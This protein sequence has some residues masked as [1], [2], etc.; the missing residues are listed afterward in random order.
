MNPTFTWYPMDAGNSDLGETLPSNGN[1]KGLVYLIRETTQNA[2]DA[3]VDGE[4]PVRVDFELIRF[5]REDVP[6]LDDFVKTFEDRYHGEKDKLLVTYRP[7]KESLERESFWTLRIGDYNT[8]GLTYECDDVECSWHKLVHAQNSTTKFGNQ[9]GSFGLG[10]GATISNSGRFQVFYGSRSRENGAFY[11]QGLS[12]LKKVQS[13][14]KRFLNPYVFYGDEQEGFPVPVTDVPN[15]KFHRRGQTEFGTDVYV[16]DVNEINV[17]FVKKPGAPL[18]LRAKSFIWCFIYNFAPALK[19]GRVTA[20]FMQDGATLL[21]LNNLDDVVDFID[22]E[23]I[24][25]ETKAQPTQF[26]RKTGNAASF[27]RAYLRDECEF[28]DIE[29]EGRRVARLFFDV[30]AKQKLTYAVRNIGMLVSKPWDKRL[31]TGV[32]IPC[33]LLEVADPTADALLRNLEE[34][35]HTKWSSH[36]VDARNEDEQPLQILLQ[37][38]LR[39]ETQRILL[40]AGMPSSDE[41]VEL[42]AIKFTGINGADKKPE[43]IRDFRPQGF[44]MPKDS[45]TKSK[46]EKKPMLGVGDEGRGIPVGERHGGDNPP[47]TKPVPPQR[48]PK[49]GVEGE[50][51][52]KIQRPLRIRSRTMA[53]DPDHGVY[54]VKFTAP[55][56]HEELLI[57]FYFDTIYGSTKDEEDDRLHPEEVLGVQG[58]VG[59]LC[60][61][62]IRVKDY[63]AGASVSLK[64]RL[65]EDLMSNLK[66]VFNGC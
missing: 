49:S 24:G 56:K 51:D 7:T 34:A 37:D 33:F 2:I 38:H 15:A 12:G 59:V 30:K 19:R 3:H 62:G 55:A 42:E 53:V 18:E 29:W 31:Q 10:R 66:V 32:V 61:D 57:R 23:V 50:G 13:G 28:A 48:N 41:V 11:F 1:F 26:A 5:K 36:A 52:Q 65:V 17:G 46:P 25:K 40:E 44:A 64:I 14:K 21:E 58:A 9:G 6:A 54:V 27:L 20:R 16:I 39:R 47:A 60:K 45:R 63:E 22:Q 8:S 35:D 43:G 4:P